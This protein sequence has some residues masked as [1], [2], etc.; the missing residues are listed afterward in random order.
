MDGVIRDPLAADDETRKGFGL[1]EMRLLNTCGRFLSGIWT[2]GTERQKEKQKRT[3]WWPRAVTRRQDAILQLPALQDRF[4][5]KEKGPT[6]MTMMSLG[7]TNMDFR[8][9]TSKVGTMRWQ[10]PESPPTLYHTVGHHV[11][12]PLICVPKVTEASR[13][14]NERH[15]QHNRKLSFKSCSVFPAFI[16]IFITIPQTPSLT[17]GGHLSSLG[18][19]GLGC[20][21]QI[22]N[23]AHLGS[24]SLRGNKQYT[25]PRPTNPWH[26]FQ[27]SQ[28]RELFRP[29]S[30]ERYSPLSQLQLFPWLQTS[31][32]KIFPR[33]STD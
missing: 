23:C 3:F 20:P 28:P 4:G 10:L 6:T 32:F 1:W 21:L 31:K 29:T 7:L 19:G 27:A 24:I 33:P 14:E 22:E 25:G 15:L 2:S 5:S 26:P 16:L 11:R 17:Q 12:K 18:L 13:K 30:T 8:V 9:P